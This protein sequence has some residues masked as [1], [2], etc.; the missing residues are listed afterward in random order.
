M[1]RGAATPTAAGRGAAGPLAGKVALVTG[2]AMGIGRG[3]A[4][5]LAAAGAR[6]AVNYRKSAT[7]AAETLRRIETA[8]GTAGLFQADVTRAA[9]ATDLVARVRR[10][11]G[12]VA[13]LVNNVGEYVEKPLETTSEAEF[14]R[15]FRSNVDTVFF[16][17]RAALPDMRRA[18][19]G[20]I[21]NITFSV[22]DTRPSARVMG[23]YTAAKA[24]VLSLTRTYAAEEIGHGITVNAVAPGVIDNGHFGDDADD[25]WIKEMPLGRFGRTDEI[26]RAVVFLADP[27]SEYI[28]GEQITVAG[29]YGL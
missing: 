25:E 1:S 4:L 29:G 7:D 22:L 5:G 2:S 6:V 13:I 18:R 11:L 8:G 10:E 20:R 17:A 19:F 3:C 27:A 26:A 15:M 24:A 23:A 12:P 14:D 16:C 28:T 9:E 21:V